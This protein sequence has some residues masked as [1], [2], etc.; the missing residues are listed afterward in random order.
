L[1]TVALNFWQSDCK[2][3]SPSHGGVLRPGEDATRVPAARQHFS[4]QFPASRADQAVLLPKCGAAHAASSTIPGRFPVAFL[5]MRL[6]SVSHL[7]QYLQISFNWSWMTGRVLP[8][9][10]EGGPPA[11]LVSW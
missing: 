5:T 3:T 6:C 4:I 11:F 10:G 8:W 9:R 2:P 1:V 7:L